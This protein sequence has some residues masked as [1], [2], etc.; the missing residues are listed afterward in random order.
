MH[1]IPWSFNQWLF[2]DLGGRAFNQEIPEVWWTEK[3]AKGPHG[4]F[5]VGDCTRFFK[6]GCTQR[7]IQLAV[8]SQKLQRFSYLHSFSHG[9]MHENHA[10]TRTSLVFFHVFHG[11]SRQ[12]VFSPMPRGLVWVDGLLGQLCLFEAEIHKQIF[13]YFSWLIKDPFMACYNPHIVG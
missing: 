7:T 5:N 13:H 11:W 6:L 2:G 9:K 3:I 4:W 8:L 1:Y 12:L 10:K